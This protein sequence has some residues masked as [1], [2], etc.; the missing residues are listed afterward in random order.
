MSR[1]QA[2]VL[3]RRRLKSGD[4]QCA[5]ALWTDWSPCSVTCGQGYRLRTRV[6]TVPFVPNRVCDNARL[7]QKQDC[8]MATCWNSDYYSGHDDTMTSSDPRT[9]AQPRQGFCVMEPAPGV[10]KSSSI[11]QWFY[12]ATESSCARFMYTGC[13]GN[14]NNFG[15]EAE[16]L[17]ACQPQGSRQTDRFR[18]LQPQSLVRE[19]EFLQRDEPARPQDCAVTQWN[20]WSPC[21]SS[22]GRG[23]EERERSVVTAPEDGGRPCPRKLVKRRRCREEVPCP[24][25]PPAWYQ[26]NWRML[27]DRQDDN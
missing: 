23:W 24:A 7:T 17:G 1:P 27:E 15:T 12:N 19:D 5:V 26:S 14:K 2:Q 3:K 20:T 22:C 11:Q 10:C 8:R 4:P 9:Q 13:G 21:S 6:Y 16:C 18:G 25:S